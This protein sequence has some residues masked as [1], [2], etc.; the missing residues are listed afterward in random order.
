M[1]SSFSKLYDAFISHRG[2]DIKETLA[3]QLYELLADRGCWAFLD[4]RELDVGDSITPA[5]ESAIY[6]SVVQIAIFSTGYAHSSWCLD[7]LVLITYCAA[8]SEYERKGRNL[9]KLDGWKK[10]LVSASD[11]VGFELYSSEDNLCKEIVS[12]VEKE[13]EKRMPLHVASYPIGLGKLVRE[14]ERRF[15]EPVKNR[16]KVVGIFGFGGSGKTTLAKEIFNTKRSEYNASCFLYDVRESHVKCEL[17][18]LQSKLLKDLFNKERKFQH[19]DEGTELLKN[20]LT[21]AGSDKRFLIIL[22][23]IDHQDQLRAL[24]FEDLLSPGSLAIVTTRDKGVLIGAEISNCY[25]MKTMDNYQAKELFRSHAFGGKKTSFPCEQLVER[26][27]KFCGGLPLLL[28]VLGTHVRGRD[29]NYWELEL[30]KVRDIQPNDVRQCLKISFDSL[31]S[32]EKQIFMD[33]AC[34]FIGREKDRAVEIWKASQWTTAEHAVQRLVDKC[35]IEVDVK[36]DEFIWYADQTP[37]FRMHDHLRD[38]GRQMADKERK[39]GF[40]NILEET[41]GR[42]YDMF[43]DSYLKF[44]IEY[45]IGNSNNYAS[46]SNALLWLGLV[47]VYKGN[48]IPSWFPVKQIRDLYASGVDELWSFPS[49]QID[50]QHNFQLRRLYLALVK[51]LEVLLL[52]N[53]E[54]LKTISGLSGLVS[55]EELRIHECSKLETIDGAQE[56][57][58]LRTLAISMS[59]HASGL[60]FLSGLKI[61]VR[62]YYYRNAVHEAVSRLNANLFSDVIGGHAIAEIQNSRVYCHKLKE[63]RTSSTAIIVCVF[64][65]SAGLAYFLENH[66]FS[67][68]ERIVTVVHT[69]QRN[70]EIKHGGA[71]ILK[72]FLATV[73]RGEEEWKA[74]SVFKV[75]IDRL[76]LQRNN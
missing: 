59:G 26:F 45:L 32:E 74:L 39:R 43:E 48:T 18:V 20:S 50:T 34:F 72:G 5:I 17:H 23:D 46:T 62:L 31:E 56:L 60:N 9:H 15:E 55:L 22:D 75:I 67:A 30:E 42:C 35:L 19:I 69:G 11:V 58:G 53:C 63:I 24:L 36:C 52:H 1:A 37:V 71:E 10:A 51:T 8:F 3:K 64:H 25:Q 54:G 27:V 61:A 14:F 68:V 21:R 40:R 2:P 29:E 13:I 44:Q 33:I 76:F 73:N 65:I 47:R 6:S 57:E 16:V 12:C 41:N 4:R 70:L 7:E 49:G 66:T 28:K 38:F